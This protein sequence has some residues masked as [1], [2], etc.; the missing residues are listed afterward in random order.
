[1]NINLKGLKSPGILP[2]EIG[3]DVNDGVG[4]GSGKSCGVL[5]ENIL[6]LYL[7]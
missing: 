5:I 7:K 4:I 2:V 3:S 1:M 6:R